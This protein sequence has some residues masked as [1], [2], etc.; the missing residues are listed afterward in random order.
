MKCYRTRELKKE[1]KR[2]N[3]Y[4]LT[5]EV[6]VTPSIMCTSVSFLSIYQ[7]K[8]F[9]VEVFIAHIKCTHWTLLRILRIIWSVARV[10]GALLP[11][12]WPKL[13]NKWARVLNLNHNWRRVYGTDLS[14]LDMHNAIQFISLSKRSVII[15]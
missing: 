3:K 2:R 8:Y 7:C 10:C 5:N 12:Y 9:L 1:S 14:W 15:H 4:L 6:L 13:R 11:F